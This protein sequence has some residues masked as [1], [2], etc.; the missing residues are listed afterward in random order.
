MRRPRP[1]TALQ[2]PRCSTRATRLSIRSS[3]ETAGTARPGASCQR[4]GAADSSCFQNSFA[5]GDRKGDSTPVRLRL[6][7]EARDAEAVKRGSGG[8]GEAGGF[9]AVEA[10]GQVGDVAEARAAEDA[11]GNGTP[12]AAF[13]LD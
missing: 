7:A 8:V 6:D 2:A 4:V 13:A 10:S 9:P 11:G 5:R 1:T 12:V 3:F